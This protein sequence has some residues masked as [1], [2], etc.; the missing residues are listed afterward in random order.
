MRI[1]FM[2]TPDFAAQALKSLLDSRHNVVGVVTQPDKPR[3]RGHK[4]TPPEVKVLAEENG[5]SVYQPE[6]LKDGELMPVLEN[7]KPDVI[8]VVAYGKILP[9]Y[10]LDFA[11]YGC[12][13]VHA[14]LLPKYRGAAPIQWAIV[15]G[16]SETGVTIMQMNEGVDTGDMLDAVRTQIDE[17]ETAELLFDR[18]A[19]LGGQLLIDTIN[20]M[21]D[22]EI[23]PVPQDDSTATY[24]PIISKS[25]GIIDWEMSARQISK[26]ICGMNSWPMA[27]TSYLG[28]PLKIVAAEISDTKTNGTAG[29]IICYDKKYGIKVQCGRGTLWIKEAQFAGSKRMSVHDYLRGHEVKTGVILGNKEN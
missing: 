24:A 1:L 23:I 11:K 29:Q 26:L 20:K 6:R 14:S 22:G 5:L 16:D 19:K 10:V 2:G 17:Y 25:D 28:E 21:E 3:G 7:L 12:V 13:N 27:Q 9:K 18:L 4:L 15:N 8:V